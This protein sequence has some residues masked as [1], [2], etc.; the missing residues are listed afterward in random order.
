[1][2]RSSQ[3][4]TT[5]AAKRSLLPPPPAPSYPDA[6]PI[7]AIG[8]GAVRIRSVAIAVSIGPISVGVVGTIGI[9]VIG[10]ISVGVIG[11]IGICVWPVIGIAPAAPVDVLLDI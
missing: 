7:T 4:S 2:R 8:V 6:W 1:M 5:P 11:T 10:P 9:C 3:R